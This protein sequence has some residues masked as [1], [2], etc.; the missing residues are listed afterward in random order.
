LTKLTAC[1][2]VFPQD[3]DYYGIEIAVLLA[4]IVVNKNELWIIVKVRRDASQ[5]LSAVPRHE[6]WSTQK[7]LEFCL[8][9]WQNH[10]K[11]DACQQASNAT[12]IAIGV[13]AHHHTTTLMWWVCIPMHKTY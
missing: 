13:L 3:T 12:K 7:K 2:I 1:F 9:Q 11:H 6:T 5:E 4:S 8:D 10:A